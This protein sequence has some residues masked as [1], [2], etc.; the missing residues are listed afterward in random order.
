MI[1]SLGYFLFSRF[2]V[3]ARDR[4]VFEARTSAPS[5][6]RALR[7]ESIEDFG[8]RLVIKPTVFWEPLDTTSLRKLIRE[9]PLVR[10]KKILEIGT[11]S[12]LVSLCCIQAGASE[13]I[14]TDVNT[15]AVECARLNAQR[16]GF[17]AKLQVKLVDTKNAKAF[18]VISAEERF[19]LIISNPPWEEGEPKSI[20][21]YALYDPN[22]ELLKSLLMEARAHLKPNGE[23][24]LAY[25]CKTAIR[26]ME[27]LAVELGYEFHVL[28][29]RKL[30]DLTEVFLP[31][32]LIKLVP[33]AN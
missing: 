16:L 17:D 11:G 21:Q 30:D 8:K 23:L 26:L 12:G 31:G 33:K 10:D 28:D 6:S 14:A 19:D 24:Y 18:A 25:G 7:S 29:D 32:M 2:Q 27:K 3:L 4:T 13:V 22:F 9:T 20:D 5:L 1:Q 15:N